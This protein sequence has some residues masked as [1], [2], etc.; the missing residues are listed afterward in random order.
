[1]F[2]MTFFALLS[3]FTRALLSVHVHM[4]VV[5]RVSRA[6]AYETRFMV[7]AFFVALALALLPLTRY[8]YAWITFDPTLGS[9]H[10]S[11]FSLE[12]VPRDYAAHSMPEDEARR[13]VV[14]GLLWCWATY[15]AWV[16]LT[17]AYCIMVVAVVIWRLW[18]DRQRTSRLISQH[19]QMID[20]QNER[21]MP[22]PHPD[23]LESKESD[24][25]EYMLVFAR[26]GA[27]RRELWALANKVLRRV[28]QF[29]P[30]SSPAIHWR[31]PGL[32]QR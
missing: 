5:Y 27:E 19:Q 29:L 13:A 31:L 8:S 25:A 30:P 16:A 12:S 3:V 7:S 24:G 10:C 1:M 23:E 18:S 28:A 11:Y 9:G 17:V 20:T 6:V 32:Q 2:G 15:F 26:W 22:E 14:S 4:V 21:E